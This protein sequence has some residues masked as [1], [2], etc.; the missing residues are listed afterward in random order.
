MAAPGP[1]PSQLD[2]AAG[3]G[4]KQSADA[5]Q[6]KSCTDEG[7]Y[8]RTES[9]A[10]LRTARSSS[11]KSGIRYICV[12]QLEAATQK[13]SDVEETKCVQSERARNGMPIP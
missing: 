11:S 7:R 9:R 6:A 8:T 3:Y 10:S 1:R 13:D 5:M 4:T 2:E 12:R